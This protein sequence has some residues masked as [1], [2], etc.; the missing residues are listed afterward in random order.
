MY[1]L[2]SLSFKPCTM[3]G[4]RSKAHRWCIDQV[5]GDGSVAGDT[6]RGAGGCL[7]VVGNAGAAKGVAATSRDAVLQWVTADGAVASMS[8]SR[9]RRCRAGRRGRVHHQ[10]GVIHRLQP[11]FFARLVRI[12]I[13]IP[14][15]QQ[16]GLQGMTQGCRVAF[17]A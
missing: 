2:G 1:L 13:L 14:E 3:R 6:G 16:Q 5:D 7:H 17:L 12:C 9:G 11:Q 8:L 4:A 10:I 15:T